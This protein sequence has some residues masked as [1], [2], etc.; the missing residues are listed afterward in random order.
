MLKLDAGVFYKECSKCGEDKASKHFR[1]RDDNKNPTRRPFCVT[2]E[3]QDRA[4]AYQR[5][6]DK[7]IKRSLAYKE[8][9]V[10]RKILGD[11][12][13]SAKRK[14]LV[15]DLTIEDIVIPS[16]CK[17]LETPLKLELGKGL[18]W[19]NPSIDRIDSSKGYTK[20][21][22]QIIS[23]KANTMKNCSTEAELL[24]FASNVLRLK[25]NSNDSP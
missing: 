22:I 16:H 2:C 10:Q 17:Y 1:I 7:R 9:N 19:S 8:Q 11:A 3:K 20:D 15:F 14:G 5:T 6:R 25:E 13:A 24:T 21:N 18:V 4:A 12:R 23:R